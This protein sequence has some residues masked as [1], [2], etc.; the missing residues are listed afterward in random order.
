M[1]M[2][3]EHL[4]A[5]PLTQLLQRQR[6]SYLAAPNPN[7]A[8]RVEQL[9]RLKAAI[10]Q[11]KTPLVEALSQDYGHRSIDDSLISDIMPVINNI[12]YSLKNLKNGSSP[13]LA[14]RGCCSPLPKSQCIINL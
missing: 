14:M 9:T 3:T 13:A 1:N 6:S 11:F 10:L 8:T 12:N 2:A 7:Y 4:N 5:S